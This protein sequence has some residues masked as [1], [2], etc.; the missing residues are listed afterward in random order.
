LVFTLINSHDSP[1][2]VSG[3][4]KEA[5]VKRKNNSRQELRHWKRKAAVFFKRKRITQKNMVPDPTPKAQI[6]QTCFM[7]MAEGSR[8]WG[9]Q[10]G[11]AE[12]P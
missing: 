7:P 12:S 3:A 11:F 5:V 2:G 1:G 6:Y 9:K 10:A 4:P 8:S